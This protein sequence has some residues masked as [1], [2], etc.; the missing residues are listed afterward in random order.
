MKKIVSKRQLYS[1]AATAKNLSLQEVSP[2]NSTYSNSQVNTQVRH[3][4]C[5]ELDTT[6]DV[7]RSSD[8]I[9]HESIYNNISETVVNYT[10][11]STCL[12]QSETNNFESNPN[13]SNQ[14]A[15]LILYTKNS[16]V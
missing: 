4:I 11:T 5:C 7:K 14:K 3:I 12:V 6:L 8:D 1:R 15:V 2:T 16:N 9:T 10:D 13:E